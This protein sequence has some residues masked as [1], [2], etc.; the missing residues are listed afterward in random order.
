MKAEL[1]L[2]D[3][4]AEL[5]KVRRENAELRATIERLESAFSKVTRVTVVD[6]DFSRVFEHYSL[7]RNGAELHLQD[8]GST[9][10]VL[11]AKED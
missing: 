5:A 9:L 3:A 10:K 8:D 11:P 2:M 1:I 6:A 4:Y 7:Y